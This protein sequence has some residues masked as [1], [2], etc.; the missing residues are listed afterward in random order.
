VIKSHNG[1]CKW[2]DGILSEHVLIAPKMRIE[3][4][5][6]SVVLSLTNTSSCAIMCDFVT[7]PSLNGR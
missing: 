1:Y 2:Q 5:V 3:A 6:A 4:I 7:P